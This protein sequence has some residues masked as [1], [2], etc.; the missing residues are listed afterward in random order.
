MS[1]VIVVVDDNP[2]NLKLLRMFLSKEGY[3]VRTATDGPEVIPLVERV[4]PDL[5]LMDIH[6]PTLDGLEVTRR[7]K[8]GDATRDIPVLA[9]TA[10]AMKGDDQKARA[11][12]CDEYITKPINMNELLE[13]VERMCTIRGNT[14]LAAEK[15]V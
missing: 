3:D 14:G 12:G 4:H 13:M 1:K 5:I 10:Y 11:A 9:V 8:A 2:A 15:P 7:L 6:L